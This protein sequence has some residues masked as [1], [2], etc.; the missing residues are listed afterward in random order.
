MKTTSTLLFHL[1]GTEPGA[2]GLRGGAGRQHGQPNWK[3]KASVS[4]EGTVV[5]LH[6]GCDKEWVLTSFDSKG[7]GG[8]C[9]M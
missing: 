1:L 8:L 9:C 4:L 6:R 7:M 5:F 2:E 3:A